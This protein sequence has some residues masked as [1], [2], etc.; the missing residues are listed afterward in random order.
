M[1]WDQWMIWTTGG[2]PGLLPDSSTGSA[3]THQALGLKSTTAKSLTMLE[4]HEY[5]TL[6]SFVTFCGLE[7]G[8]VEIVDLPSHLENGEFPAKCQRLPGGVGLPEFLPKIDYRGLQDGAPQWC[9]LVYNPHEYYSYICHKPEW[10]GSYVHQ[11]SD[12][13][14]GHHLVLNH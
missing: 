6:W 10:N 7:H 12:S 3:A 8:P 5:S 1:S 2:C 11:L 14:L 13:E 4:E 9:L